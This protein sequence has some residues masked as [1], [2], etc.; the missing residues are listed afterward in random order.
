MRKIWGLLFFVISFHAY[1]QY[2][3]GTHFKTVVVIPAE[4][5]ILVN[6]ELM[7]KGKC[8]VSFDN[9]EKVLLTFRCNGYET[10][11]YYLL[12][13]NTERTVTYRL[14]ADEAYLNSEGDET[15]SQ[16]ANRWVP[17]VTRNGLSDDEAWLRIMSIV[18]ENFEYIEIENEDDYE[19]EKREFV[20]FRYHCPKCNG[21]IKRYHKFG[22]KAPY[23]ICNADGDYVLEYEDGYCYL[24]E[25]LDYELA[26]NVKE[27]CRERLIEERVVLVSKFAEKYKNV[28]LIDTMSMYSLFELSPYDK[29]IGI[30]E[31]Q[32][33]FNN[34][35]ST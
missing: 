32:D 15:A 16:Y 10:S 29:E 11:T 5:E 9:R 28:D 19:Y 31:K 35:I 23:F 6:N 27:T 1:S 22:L 18:R 7:G 13:N 17:L 25:Y 34:F 30:D 26:D 33:N 20:D 4:A 12:K 14:E 24:S 3:N 2:Y 21:V 8:E